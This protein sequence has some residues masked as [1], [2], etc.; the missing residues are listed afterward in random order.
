[1]L[2]A[3]GAAT[4]CSIQGDRLVISDGAGDRTVEFVR[5]A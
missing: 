3:L 2:A 5:I 1:M 4:S